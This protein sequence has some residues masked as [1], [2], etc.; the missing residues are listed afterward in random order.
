MGVALAT[1]EAGPGAVSS[2]IGGSGAPIAGE[3]GSGVGA[4]FELVSIGGGAGV[5]LSGGGPGRTPSVEGMAGENGSG[6]SAP[7]PGRLMTGVLLTG[8]GGELFGSLGDDG[9]GV[10]SG[11]GLPSPLP[12]RGRL[13]GGALVAIW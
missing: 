3:A 12:D 10:G 5:P 2:P 1:L 7:P 9:G 4:G 6:A 13:G 11:E 8:L